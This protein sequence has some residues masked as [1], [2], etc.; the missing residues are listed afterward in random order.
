MGL[1]APSTLRQLITKGGRAATL[2][3]DGVLLTQ[4]LGQL[5]GLRVGDSVEL[6]LREGDR[7][8]VSAP[9][10]GFID[11]TV[12]L[13][14]YAPTSLVN[15]LSGD[16]GA[17][18]SVLLQVN[19]SDVEAVEAQLRRSP[20]IIDVSDVHADKRRLFDMNARIMDVWTAISISLAASVA[21]GVVYNNARINLG[22]RSRELASLRVLGFSRR[23]VSAVL[24]ASLALEVLI[25]IPIGLVLGH[26]WAVQFMGSVD[27]ETF[28][29]EVVVS[30]RT[31]LLVILVVLLAASASALW[32]RRNVD[33]FD[34]MSVLKARD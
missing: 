13:W 10:V 33:R 4:T 8:I 32:V 29:W 5:L 18:S 14:V 26:F 9:I 30:P 23:E 6:E 22:A 12:G 16:W 3:A 7:R 2:P 17:V 34:L 24:L 15:Q 28:R 11:E 20:E 31:Y 1:P 27:P 19:S 21:F 25:G